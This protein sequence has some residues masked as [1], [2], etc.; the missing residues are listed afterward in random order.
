MLKLK[1]GFTGS[2]M[3]VLPPPITEALANDQFTSRL[4][5][6]DIGHFPHARHHYRNRPEGTDAWILLYCTDGKGWVEYK[7]SRYYLNPGQSFIIPAGAP[8]TYGADDHVPWTLYWVHFKGEL[9]PYFAEDCDK[10]C[11]MADPDHDR[12]TGRTTLFEEL[13]LAI[14]AG[15]GDA[16]LRYASATLYHFLGTFRYLQ[17]GYKPRQDGSGLGIIE[18]C[19]SYMLEHIEQHISLDDL[20][21]FT[22][23]SPARCNAVFKQHTGMTPVAYLQELR[24]QTAMQLFENTDLHVNQVCQKVGIEDPYYFSRLFRKHTGLSP[25]DWRRQGKKV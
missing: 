20:C 23:F 21:R 3:V 22:G 1:D 7:G 10:V 6:T 19:R 5:L 16:Q 25:S 11:A 14:E 2:R 12:I 24:I 17:A 18:R 8:H 9:A 15:Y 4:Y 13:F